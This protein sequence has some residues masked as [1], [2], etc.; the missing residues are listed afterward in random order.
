M[1]ALHREER[2]QKKEPVWIFINL[3]MVMM[4]PFSLIAVKLLFKCSR[5][6]PLSIHDET[7]RFF[8]LTLNP[9]YL[10]SFQYVLYFVVDNRHM[11][12]YEK[13]NNEHYTISTPKNVR[14][15]REQKKWWNYRKKPIHSAHQ[16]NW[17]SKLWQNEHIV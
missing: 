15:I 8:S 5:K 2:E 7:V 9:I 1:N 16:M 4:W 13:L 6:I 11:N 17:T 12:D 10:H 3:L 14:W